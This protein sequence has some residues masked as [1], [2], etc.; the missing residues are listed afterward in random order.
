MRNTGKPSEQIF[1]DA[2]KRLGKKAYVFTFTDTARARGR[3]KS[4][5]TIEAQPADRLLVY[6]G[7][8]SFAEIKSTTDERAFRFSLL[9]KSQSFA[10]AATMAAGGR[11]DV[12]LH[13]LAYDRWYRIPYRVIAEAKASGKGSISFFDLQ[14]YLWSFPT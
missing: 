7:E 9:R 2:W 10:A 5:V 14:P 8:I 1:D 4:M 3:S 13:A 11:Y 6:E 12:F